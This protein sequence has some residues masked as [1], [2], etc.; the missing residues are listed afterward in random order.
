MAANDEKATQ[1]PEK[2]ATEK[3][4]ADVE[5]EF[6]ETGR[7][8]AGYSIQYVRRGNQSVAEVKKVG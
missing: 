3:Q 5:R 7:V 4:A 6:L 1:A 2:K 8:P